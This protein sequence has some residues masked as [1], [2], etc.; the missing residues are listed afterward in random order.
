[1]L[2]LILASSDM[3]QE[4]EPDNALYTAL[5]VNNL[6]IAIWLLRN[7]AYVQILYSDQGSALY[8]AA[9]KGYKRVMEELLNAAPPT[10]GLGLQRDLIRGIP[11]YYA[12]EK[13]HLGILKLLF[14]YGYSIP[15]YDYL[16][17]QPDN[18]PIYLASEYGHLEVVKYLLKQSPF[19]T[20]TI[21]I[22]NPE[23]KTPLY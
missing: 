10:T 11:F 14:I 4:R 8:V 12:T 17:V 1:M 18:Y 7:G 9:E 6:E 23:G 5:R 2:Q 19:P 16:H 22:R 13:G 21:N 20:E 3:N 15:Q